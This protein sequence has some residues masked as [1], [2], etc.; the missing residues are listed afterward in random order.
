MLASQF[1]DK[2]AGFIVL[3]NFEPAGIYSLLTLRQNIYTDPQKPIQVSPGLYEIGEPD[4]RFAAA[5][6]HQLL[7]HLLLRGRRGGGQ[8]ASAPGCWS[9]TP[10]G[11]R[12]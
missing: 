5:G 1:I 8:R 7:P 12:C 10:R 6:H 11:C 9:P 3:D 2:Y 4:A